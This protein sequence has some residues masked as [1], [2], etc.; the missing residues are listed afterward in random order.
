MSYQLILTER[1]VDGQ[2]TRDIGENVFLADLPTEYKVYVF[3]Y[4]G[5]MGNE[6]LEGRLRALG[7]IAGK[8]L[9]TSGV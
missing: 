8:N 6:T 9:L 1:P 4:A 7:E 2:I 3:Y 5:A